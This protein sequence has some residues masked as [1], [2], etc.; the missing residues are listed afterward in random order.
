MFK[1]SRKSF[2]RRTDQFKKIFRTSR[3]RLKINI[4]IA[5]NDQN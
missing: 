5:I 4:Q 3:Y 2:D 1:A